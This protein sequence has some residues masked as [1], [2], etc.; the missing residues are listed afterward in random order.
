MIRF[1]FAALLLLPVPAMAQTAAPPMKLF[2]AGADI[3]AVIAQAKAGKVRILASW[4]EKRLAA[5]ATV[6]LLVTIIVLIA[7]SRLSVRAQRRSAQKVHPQ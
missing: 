6:L 4:G 7:H 1:L 3:P 2:T 5:I